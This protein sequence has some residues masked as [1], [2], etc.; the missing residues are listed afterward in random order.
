MIKDQGCPTCGSKNYGNL[1][2]KK[3]HDGVATWK[4]QCYNCKNFWYL[5]SAN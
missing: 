2:I 3:N 4:K 1:E 5:E